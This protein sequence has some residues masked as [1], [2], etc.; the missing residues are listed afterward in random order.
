[1]SSINQ[2]Q[3]KLNDDPHTL[4]Q[5]SEVSND[6]HST[7]QK[8]EVSNDLQ[9]MI[10]GPATNP[11]ITDH[12]SRRQFLKTAGS[13]ALLAA[14][15][16]VIPGCSDDSN[17]VIGPDDES[18]EGIT[19]SGNTIRLNL[20]SA[21]V[22]RLASAGGWLLIIAAQTLA[23]NIDGTQIR[24]FTSI[25]THSN[26]D[27]NWNYVGQQFECTCHG[28][29]FSNAGAVVRGPATRNLTEFAVTRT[30]NTV[31]INKS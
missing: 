16:I 8:S 15:G 3:S 18:G 22:S 19:I 21:D 28:S 14:L 10:Q 24:A 26:C 9:S 2:V 23:V 29:R 7:V 6:L 25:C 17:N 30:G 5:K 12:F 1:M 4:V 27:R 11:E 20:G 13:V 31:T